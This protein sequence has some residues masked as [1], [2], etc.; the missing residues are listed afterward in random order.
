MGYVDK[1]AVCDTRMSFSGGHGSVDRTPYGEQPPLKSL[2]GEHDPSTRRA[3]LP[4][5]RRSGPLY[6]IPG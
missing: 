4:P 3:P 5:N 2:V 1:P 6:A